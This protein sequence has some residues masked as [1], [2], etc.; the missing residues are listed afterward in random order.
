METQDALKRYNMKRSTFYGK[1]K[2]IRDAD[3]VLPRTEKGSA[4][5]LFCSHKLDV[6]ARAGTLGTS[7]RKAILNLDQTIEEKE[8][9]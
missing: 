7:A 9:R 2:V 4:R 8:L 3:A 6:L 1:I 5:N